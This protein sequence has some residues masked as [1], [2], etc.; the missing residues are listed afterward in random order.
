MKNL[1]HKAVQYA[2]GIYFESNGHGTVF[3]NFEKVNRWAKLNQVEQTESFKTL[4]AY[5][6]V[7]NHCVGDAM[8]DALALE[9][10]LR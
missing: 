10:S 2:V 1:H 5:L 6:D 7:F 8:V 9:L 4:T 3:V